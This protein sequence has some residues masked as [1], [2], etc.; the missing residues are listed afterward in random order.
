MSILCRSSASPSF[1]VWDIQTGIIINHSDIQ[2]LSKVMCFGNQRILTTLEDSSSDSDDSDGNNSDNSN[3]DSSDSNDNSNY[4]YYRYK[5]VFSTYNPLT[6]TCLCR[7]TLKSLS[8]LCLGPYWAHKES[9]QFATSLSTDGE[10]VVDIYEVQETSNPPLSLIQ[11]F[12]I[13]PHDGIF[14]FS[15]T[16][17][18]ASFVSETEVVILDVQD[19][20]V[21]FHTKEGQKLYTPPGQFSP[22]GSSFACKTSQQ[23]ICVWKNTPIG[24]VPWSHLKPR[25]PFVDFAFSPT[26]NSIVA[27]S[28]E[29]IQLL[30]LDNQLSPPSTEMTCKNGDHLV[31]YSVDRTYIAT[32][33]HQ[34]SSVTVLFGTSQQHIDTGM[35]IQDI[36]IVNNTL[37]VADGYKVLSWHFNSS[38]VAHSAYEVAVNPINPSHKVHAI[39]CC[40]LSN[41]CSQIAIATLGSISL[42]GIEPQGSLGPMTASVPYATIHGL[43]F[44]PDGCQL[45]ASINNSFKYPRLLIRMQI[46]ED[47]HFG[48]V[49]RSS[50]NKWS[51]VDIFSPCNY[52]IGRG[53][54]WVMDSRSVDNIL[55]LPLSWRTKS[56]HQVRWDGNFLALVGAHHPEPIIIEFQPQS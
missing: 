26:T 20:G 24:Y 49:T 37:F 10:F 7:G 15:P 51:W 6:S 34:D 3:S 11:S 35:A 5:Y 48:N 36:R 40:A 22:D 50:I 30:H 33:R 54:G 29:G 46:V 13:L 28:Q 4:F 25:S 52:H 45:W 39:D 31:A 47:Q 2:N 43:R 12:T 14:S 41:N 21:L 19:S 55:W 17:L 8:E 32:A 1:V 18:Q 9:F 23:D 42:H 53:S 38:G 27:W 16:S 56:A 44:S